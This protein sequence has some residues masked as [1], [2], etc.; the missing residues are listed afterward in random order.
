MKRAVASLP[1]LL[2]VLL[3]GLALA[4]Q[5]AWAGAKTD[6]DSRRN[7]EVRLGREAEREVEKEIKLSSDQAMIQRVQQIGMKVAEI[8]NA[9]PVQ[10]GYGDKEVYR[11]DYRFKVVD[12]KD[13]NAFSLPGGIIYVN[14]GLLS[15]VKSDHE[16]AGVLAHEVAHAAHHHMAYL[17]RQQNKMDGKI[18]LLLLAGM[19]A[20][21]DSQDLG[22]L[23]IGAQL[24]RTAKTNGYGQKAEMDADVSGVTYMVKAGY[25]PVGMLT[26]LER[27]SRTSTS[28]PGL[29]LGILQTHPGSRDR[30]KY[31]AAQ[32]QSMGLAVNRQSITG[33]LTAL[34]EPTQADGRSSWQVKLGD[35][36]L[37]EPAPIPDGVSAEQRAKMMA[38]RVNQSMAREPRLRDVTV[39]SDGKSVMIHGETVVSVTSEDCAQ[40]GKPAKEVATVAA[41]VIRK[42]IW[43]DEIDQ[44][45]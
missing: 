9:L 34:A 37:F 33:S 28:D 24:M 1:I 18:A 3:I 42:A 23:L 32:I 26:F 20:R 40:C 10:A 25:N 13:V 39:G 45:Y 38:V 7:D 12:D 41:N 14:T 5:P 43:R 31:V 15:F 29:T 2:Y 17:T 21:V 19:L 16:L 36:L 44:L 11:F 6:P 22:N 35:D 4:V 27:L 8:A 30:C